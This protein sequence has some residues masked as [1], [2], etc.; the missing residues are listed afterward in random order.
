MYTISNKIRSYCNIE[1]S[2][3]A[4]CNAAFF[5]YAVVLGILKVD[6]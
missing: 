2:N 5:W 4:K 1:Q 3:G 6:D